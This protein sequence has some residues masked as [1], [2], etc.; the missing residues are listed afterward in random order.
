MKL[1]NFYDYQDNAMRLILYLGRLI[2]VFVIGS[3]M[4]WLYRNILDSITVSLR[5]YRATR[6]DQPEQTHDRAGS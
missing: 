4:D 2:F 3:F 5:S 1:S 6:S